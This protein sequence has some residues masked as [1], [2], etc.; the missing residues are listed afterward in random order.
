MQVTLDI[1]FFTLKIHYHIFQPEREREREKERG[2]RIDKYKFHGE[3]VCVMG[4]GIR[5]PHRQTREL[6]VIKKKT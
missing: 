4:R 1:S 5:F 3:W 2:K 6:A